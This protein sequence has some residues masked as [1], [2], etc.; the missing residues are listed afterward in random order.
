MRRP[1]YTHNPSSPSE[2][3]LI[4]GQADNW[5]HARRSL[6]K[7]SEGRLEQ[8]RNSRLGTEKNNDL[9]E[10]V[11]DRVVNLTCALMVAKDSFC[12]DQQKVVDRAVS[13]NDT[14]GRLAYQL[15]LHRK[16]RLDDIDS[17]DVF[18]WGPQHYTS[19]PKALADLFEAY[20]GAVYEEHGWDATK[21]WLETLFTPL[22][23]KATEDHLK[24]SVLPG[25]LTQAIYISHELLDNPVHQEKLHDYLE[26]KAK[27]FLT[28]AE[29]ALSALPQ[30]T[31]FVFGAKGDIGNDRDMVEIATHLVKFWVCEIFMSLYPENREALLKGPHLV[32]SI[33]ILVT[34]TWTLGCLGSL[35]KLESFFDV[36]DPDFSLFNKRLKSPRSESAETNNRK[37]AF[38]G[39][40][41]QAVY[42]MIGWYHSK[43][44]AAAKK[45]GI[46]W[47]RPLVTRAH[48]ILMEDPRFVRCLK[49]PEFH[50]N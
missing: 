49:R 13:S 48:D 28:M 7:L 15:H 47:L 37:A 27:Q 20:A 35:L 25:Y 6:P 33:T 4:L 44:A 24:Q 21:E 19:P 39:K 43:D 14:L 45:W 46:K 10:F 41:T 36:E 34:N 17:E 1:S 40:L 18:G 12:P 32:S 5:R 9:M 2:L 11:G 8:A 50:R 31:K 29:P 38:R 3:C 30:S 23:E 42:A 26:F 16:A 22:I